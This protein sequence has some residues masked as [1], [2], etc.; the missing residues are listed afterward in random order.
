MRVTLKGINRATMRLAD[1]R[2]VT[3]H[4]ACKGGPRL[5]GKPGSPEFIASYNEAI[6]QRVV[7][8][9]ALLLSVLQAFQHSQDF[10]GLAE[11]TRADYVAKIRLIEKKF[12]DFPLAA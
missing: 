3:Y 12:D 5:R 6:A 7:A 9:Q 11:R 2:I 4:Y 8:P 10:L 1:G